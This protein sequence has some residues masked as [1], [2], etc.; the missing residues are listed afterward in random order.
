MIKSTGTDMIME[1]KKITN[2]PNIQYI[3]ELQHVLRPCGLN[4]LAD[5]FKMPFKNDK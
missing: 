2:V 4:E 1:K 5:N 3:H